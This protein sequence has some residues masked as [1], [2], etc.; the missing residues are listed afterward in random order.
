MDEDV[1][2]IPK[3]V[4]DVIPVKRIW[5]DGIFLV[6]KDKY[7]KTFKFTDINFIVAGEEDK[8][9]MVVDYIDILNSFETD[10]LVKISIL[11]SNINEK[12]IE[13]NIKIEKE[14][15]QT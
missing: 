5:N 3:S 4:Q 11:N 1:F 9:Q 15:R 14:K 6:E 8:E 10:M 13:N 7:S 12:D 2:K